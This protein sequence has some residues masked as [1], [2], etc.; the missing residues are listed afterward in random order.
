MLLPPSG[1]CLKMKKNTTASQCNKLS[2][3]AA[4]MDMFTKGI[5][6]NVFNRA[7]EAWPDADVTIVEMGLFARQGYEDRMAIAIAGLMNSINNIVESQQFSGRYTITCIDEAHKLVQ[8]PLIGPY[9]NSISAM[10]R[11]FG[12]WLWLSTQNLHQFPEESRQLLNQPEW[13]LCLNTDEDE[14][15]QIARFKE[16]STEQQAL[17][18]AARKEQGK[19]TEGVVMSKKILTLFRNVPPALALAIAMTEAPEKAQRHR[20]MEKHNCSELDAA[21]MIAEK[22]NE[23]RLRDEAMKLLLNFSGV[24]FWLIFVFLCIAGGYAC[25]C[26]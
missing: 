22:I 1:K 25:S 4:A 6:G 10:W 20:L 15:Q 9:I 3:R 12:G 17:L 26:Q 8:N 11:T 14:V 19:Y 21:R 2:S 7:G 18:K 16:L 5:E 24:L 13:W 23:R